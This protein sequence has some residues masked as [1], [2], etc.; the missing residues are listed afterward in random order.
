MKSGD[1]GVDIFFVLSG[2]LIGFILLKE[3]IKYGG[4]IDVWNFYRGR[5]LRLW[6]MVAFWI[7][8]RFIFEGAIAGRMGNPDLWKLLSVLL[9][10]NNW[11]GAGDQGW[12]LAVEF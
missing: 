9:F 12:S 4:K 10:M 5:F 1:I 8:I 3:F 7:F 11:T 6:P 2:F